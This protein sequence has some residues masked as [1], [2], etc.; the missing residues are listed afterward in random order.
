M[1]DA[2]MQSQATRWW[3]LGPISQPLAAIALQRADMGQRLMR[4]IAPSL[5]E[6]LR[7]VPSA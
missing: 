6:R 5:A 7:K 2:L 3:P 1:A 4:N